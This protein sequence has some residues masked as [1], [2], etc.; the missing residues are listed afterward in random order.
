MLANL[1]SIDCNCERRKSVKLNYSVCALSS[2]AK[3]MQDGWTSK[4]RLF[5]E[6]MLL[7]VIN[8]S[9]ENSHSSSSLDATMKVLRMYE[10][11]A[12]LERR[13]RHRV[14]I[15]FLSLLTDQSEIGNAMK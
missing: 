6:V 3:R 5:F 9:A 13:S 4:W 8:S 7:E 1:V 14:S 12:Q 11:D 10:A 15:V 2:K